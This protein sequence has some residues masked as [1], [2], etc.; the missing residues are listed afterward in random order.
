MYEKYK[1]LDKSCK[2]SD[3]DIYHERCVLLESV[4]FDET[5]LDSCRG[6]E[7]EVH[8]SFYWFVQ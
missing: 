4:G 8:S 7:Q 2:D 1:L 3:L 5:F 6:S